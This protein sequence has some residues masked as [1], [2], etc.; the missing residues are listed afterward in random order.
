MCTLSQR[1]ILC[2]FIQESMYENV[3][4]VEY[5]TDNF[6]WIQSLA[7]LSVSLRVTYRRFS[8]SM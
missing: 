2:N 3:P 1:N 8:Q 6:Y 7:V 4:D 5:L